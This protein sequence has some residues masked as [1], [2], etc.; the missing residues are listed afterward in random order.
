MTPS[1]NKTHKV[2]SALC[3]AMIDADTREW[4]P[5]CAFFAYQ[6]FRPKHSNLNEKEFANEDQKT[7]TP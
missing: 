7:K 2:L 3:N 1:H 6:P 4:P 5:K